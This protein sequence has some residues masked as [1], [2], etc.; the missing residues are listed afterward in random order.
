MNIHS[1]SAA[2]SAMSTRV[3]D[4]ALA[5]FTERTFGGSAVPQVAE[6]AGIGVGTIYRSFSG[7]EELANGVYRRAKQAMLDHLV[8]ALAASGP[9][10][11]ERVRAVWSGLA[12]YA[13]SDPDGFAFLEHQQ[14][15]AYLDAES[16][17]LGRRI[18]AFAEE[19]VRDGQRSGELRDAD[20]AMLVALVFGAFVG[21]T[22]QRR[23]IGLPLTAPDLEVAGD[24]VWHL[25]ARPTTPSQEDPR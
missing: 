11:R 6:R 12:A 21:L 5:V 25:V 16:L 20:P 7:K 18:D 4:A 19:L 3:L 23:S 1:V 13:A 10:T 2:A 24:A 8:E 9:G 17:E 22:K 15:A 14:H